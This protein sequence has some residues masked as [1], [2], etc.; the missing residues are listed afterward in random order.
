MGLFSKKNIVK[1]NMSESLAG[2]LVLFLAQGSELE[3]KEKLYKGR[4]CKAENIFELMLFNAAYILRIVKIEYP[5]Y[6][7]HVYATILSELGDFINYNGLNTLLSR[8]NTRN[9]LVFIN[10]SSFGVK[11]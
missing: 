4:Y 8:K 3:L 11:I 10:D 9:Q 5:T 7:G 6:I 1:L 2:A